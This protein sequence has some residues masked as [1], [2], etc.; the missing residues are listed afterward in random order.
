[1]PVLQLQQTPCKWFI[2][3]DRGGIAQGIRVGKRRWRHSRHIYI[4]TAPH[5]GWFH[6]VVGFLMV[7]VFPPHRAAPCA[8]RHWRGDIA[9]NGADDSAAAQRLPAA[10][11]R[12]AAAAP[13]GA[14]ATPGAVMCGTVFSSTA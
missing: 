3:D 14:H 5:A 13:S 10:D 12:H 8:G 6:C 2:Q 4:L 9:A 7:V 11:D 1:M